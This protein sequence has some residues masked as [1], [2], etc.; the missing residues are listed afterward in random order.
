M[1][2]IKSKQK[3]TN[4][5]KL[6]DTFLDSD[7][8]NNEIE[9]KNVKIKFIQ[10]PHIVNSYPDIVGIVWDENK[11]ENWNE[12]R[13]KLQITDLKIMHHLYQRNLF[14][15]PKDLVDELGYSIKE[16]EDS[17]SRVNDANLVI[18]NKKKDKFKLK[19]ISEIFFISEI[20][21]IE[22]KLK[23]WSDVLFQ[24]INNT[25]FSSCSYSLVPEEII[26]EKMLKNFR[27]SEIGIIAYN[28]NFDIVHKPKK[29]KI[30]ASFG[31]WL[32][33]EYIGHIMN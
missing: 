16:V 12:N 25:W 8:Y 4:E 15:S 6:V 14:K 31:S 32:F 20:I 7:F 2:S 13:K 5:Q 28:K 19:P 10:E 24:S 29:R 22:A 26:N 27:D 18:S 33:N 23:K 21:S 1:I 17:F 11:L 9:G 30:P 3:P